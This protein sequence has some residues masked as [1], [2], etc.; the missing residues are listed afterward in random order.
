MNEKDSEDN[1]FGLYSKIN[2]L[3][4]FLLQ[5]CAG[6]FLMLLACQKQTTLE[7]VDSIFILTSSEIKQDSLLPQEY[8]CDGERATLPLEWDGFPEDTKSFA[9]IMHHEAS[10][11]DIHWYWVLY[12]IPSSIHSLPKNVNGIG[13]LGNNSVN[14]KTEYAPPCSQGPGPKKYTYTIYSL[15]EAVNLSVP[16]S[17]VSREVLLD[18]IKDI[19]LASATLNVIYSRD[20]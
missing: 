6:T 18:A 5:V 12:D 1:R 2:F 9:L 3:L 13:T 19:T 14:G 7:S 20:I 4:R 10:S 15:S 17:E 16:N 8:T 11:I